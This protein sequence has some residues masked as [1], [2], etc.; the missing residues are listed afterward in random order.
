MIQT[1]DQIPE[2]LGR[3]QQGE[4]VRADQLRGR[5]V[6]LYFY[7]K[8][9]MTPCARKGMKSSVAAWTMRPHTRSS[10]PN[11]NCRSA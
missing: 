7:P 6:I 1:G 11:T 5:K 8:D 10:S 9:N 2:V 4:E 3:D